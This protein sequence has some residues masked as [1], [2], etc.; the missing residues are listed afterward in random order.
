MILTMKNSVIL[1]FIAAFSLGVTAQKVKVKKGEV[2]VDKNPVAHIEEVGDTYVFS[3]TGEKEIPVFKVKF[4]YMK[5]TEDVSKKWLA[6]SYPDER[7]STE[8][9]MEYISFTM[10]NKKAVAE[11]LMKRHNIFTSSGIDKEALDKFMAVDRPDLTKQYNELLKGEVSKERTVA[12]IN[13]S[14]DADYNR[15][16]KGSVPY[17]SSSTDERL[18]TSGK[19]EN[20]LGTYAMDQGKRTINVYDLDN[21]KVAL[22]TV[23]MFDDVSV[24]LPYAE[25]KFTYKAKKRF[26]ANKYSQQDFVRELVGNLYLR[27]VTLGHQIRDEREQEFAARRELSREEYEIA[28]ENSINI[29]D[30]PGYVIDEKG[31]R[32]EG[33][34]TML[35]EEIIAPGEENVAELGNNIGKKLTL[36]YQN[37]KGKTRYKDFKSKNETMFCTTTP[38]GSQTCYRGLRVKGKGA[39]LAVNAVSSLSFDTSKFYEIIEEKDNISLYKELLEGKYVIKIKKEKKGYQFNV[40]NREKNLE[41]LTEYIGNCAIK[42]Q[43]PEYDYTNLESIKAFI[44][45]YNS[46]CK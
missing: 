16:F 28:K 44:E 40:R 17:T 22:A 29:Y 2:L 41:K 31:E 18:R 12:N 25:K 10:N 30:K 9:D 19:Y 1:I 14:V 20:L 32:Y 5:L 35:W 11:F 27:G 39:E 43:V 24:T 34:I 45:L 21:K 7:K 13:V 38:D 3:E 4:H 36:K 15:I 26:E 6:V 46:S 23:S 8:V 42:D 37:K 33:T